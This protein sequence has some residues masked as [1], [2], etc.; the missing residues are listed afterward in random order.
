M[1]PARSSRARRRRSASYGLL[2][3]GAGALLTSLAATAAGIKRVGEIE[4]HCRAQDG[5]QCSL[6]EAQ[7]LERKENLPLLSGLSIGGAVAGGV[8]VATGGVLWLTLSRADRTPGNS[9][10]LLIRLGGAF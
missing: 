10:S 9:A 8:S 6:D 1:E 3:F 2:G 5:A 4:A 7:R